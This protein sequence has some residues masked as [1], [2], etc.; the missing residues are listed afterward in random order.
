[1]T[2]RIKRFA[3]WQ[4][5]TAVLLM[6]GFNSFAQESEIK[7]NINPIYR[8][9]D[10]RS[11]PVGMEPVLSDPALKP[12]APP[13]AAKQSVTAPI[14]TKAKIPV[15]SL[16]PDVP[17]GWGVN[18]VASS[19]L[20]SPDH[21]PE[22]AAQHIISDTP[23]FMPVQPQPDAAPVAALDDTPAPQNVKL[24][25]V[26]VPPEPVV[27]AGQTP[28][29]GSLDDAPPRPVPAAAVPAPVSAQPQ[30]AGS[31]TLQ[32][33][34]IDAD[35]EPVS[36][37]RPEDSAATGA[38]DS[39]EAASTAAQ[40]GPSFAGAVDVLHPP[41]PAIK[42]ELVILD[43]P[44]AAISPASA[45][46]AEDEPEPA[47]A[48]SSGKHTGLTGGARL[49]FAAGVEVMD[50]AALKILDEQVFPYLRQEKSG[51]L[52]LRAFASADAAQLAGAKRIALSRALSLREY[53]I[54]HG[55]S[56]S[57]I[58]VQILGAETDI[59]PM[60]RVDILFAKP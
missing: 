15:P 49:L 54:N 3:I 41:L 2:K 16:K 21:M 6:F 50:V 8:Y 19:V 56:S 14:V 22:K 42:P 4:G 29:F 9:P 45:P 36:Q 10:L 46:L 48:P 34:A 37:T 55:V 12:V 38:Q 7:S 35:E 26:S 25:P 59:T 5:L 11:A 23:V 33:H 58:D 13:L 32:F 31:Q 57:R 47:P 40:D 39:A 43:A 28:V 52:M 1:M 30:D 53:L 51:T 20:P 24:Q 60:D 44:L 27:A 17:A 18:E